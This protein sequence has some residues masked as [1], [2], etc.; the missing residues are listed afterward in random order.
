MAAM[1]TEA[2]TGEVGSAAATE[3]ALAVEAVSV[4]MVVKE[5]VPVV[6]T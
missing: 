3:A 1:A 4:G 6:Q 5:A 2:S